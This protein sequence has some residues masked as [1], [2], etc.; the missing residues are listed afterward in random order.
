MYAPAA[1]LLLGNRGQ[2][3]VPRIGHSPDTDMDDRRA[4]RAVALAMFEYGDL[5]AALDADRR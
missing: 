2:R 5:P 3:V 4:Q 1:E